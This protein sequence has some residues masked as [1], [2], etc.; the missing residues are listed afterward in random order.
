MMKVLRLM[1][2][3]IPS[4]MSSQAQAQWTVKITPTLNPLP[5]GLCAAI[6]LSVTDSTNQVPRNSS[7]YRVT[8]S[9]FDLSVTAPNPAAVAGIYYGASNWSVC[10]CQKARV[11]SVAT[12]TASYPAV[13]L[14]PTSRVSGVEV[15]ASETFVIGNPVNNTDQPACQTPVASRGKPV[16]AATV[17]AAPPTMPPPTS[18][19]PSTKP[20]AS[21][22][23][24]LPTGTSAA[25]G[26]AA[27]P[28]PSGTVAPPPKPLPRGPAPESV[29]VKGSATEAIITWTAPSVQ[30]GANSQSPIGYKVERW[31]S[32][33]PE[34]CRSSSPTLTT[35][36]WRDPLT[37]S[38]MWRYRVIALYADGR[39]GSTLSD[40]Y[41]YTGKD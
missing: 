27:I 35:L 22:S 18:T 7:S 21:A 11:G 8:L 33:D 5:I 41:D 32:G 40:N 26:N 16:A 14:A 13:A 30:T 17:A 12:I 2:V 39:R 6:R 10:A 28:A 3:L 23:E 29:S 4:I 24:A 20:P 34:C 25:T 1:L 9:D 19:A 15:K 37:Q 31:K 36:E 38:G